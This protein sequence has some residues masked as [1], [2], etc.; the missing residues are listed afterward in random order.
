MYMYMDDIIHVYMDEIIHE[1][2]IHLI[3]VAMAED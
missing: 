1:K 2:C 3:T